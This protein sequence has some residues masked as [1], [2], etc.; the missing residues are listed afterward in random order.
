MH[1][2]RIEEVVGSNPITST[3]IRKDDTALDVTF[4]PYEQGI[5]FPQSFIIILEKYPSPAEGD[6]LEMH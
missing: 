3:F 4:I 5:K 1:F 6:A 2:T